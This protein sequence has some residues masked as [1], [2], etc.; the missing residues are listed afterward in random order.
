MLLKDCDVDALYHPEKANVVADGRSRGSI[1][2]LA[3]LG[4]ER[5]ELV[6]SYIN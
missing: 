6:E 2:S 3:Y 5:R 1:N 4:V